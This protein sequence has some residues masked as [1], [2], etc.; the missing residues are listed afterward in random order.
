MKC[1]RTEKETKIIN[2]II[3]VLKIS[4]YVYEKKMPKVNI[5]NVI[6]PGCPLCFYFKGRCNLNACG[7]SVKS[8]LPL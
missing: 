7:L 3:H 4:K 6:G 5:K 1:G 8:K 2:I